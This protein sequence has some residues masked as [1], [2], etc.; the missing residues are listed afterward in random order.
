[1]VTIT[2]VVQGISN[3]EQDCVDFLKEFGV[4]GEDYLPCP[5]TKH[6]SFGKPMTQGIRR[7]T[8]GV[9]WKCT[10]K[11]C[12]VL[13]SIRISN[14]FFTYIDKNRKLRCGLSLQKITLFIYLWA[15][16]TNNVVQMM[17]ILR[18]CRQTVVDWSNMC[19]EVCSIIIQR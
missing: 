1:M 18:I 11:G 2:E 16:T 5:G 7:D 8:N 9:I 4:F 15:E 13:R 12:R 17:R 14:G 10:G 19:R 3:S 6:R